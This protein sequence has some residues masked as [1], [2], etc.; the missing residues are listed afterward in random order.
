MSQ[1]AIYLA[2][3]G[4]NATMDRMTAAANNL[5]N[6]S[7]TAFKAQQ[8]VFKAE[9][10]VGQGLP[11][12]VDVASSE[13]TADFK[14]GAL[15]QT[16]RSLDVAVGGSGWIA[17]QANDGTPALTR[18]GALSISQTGMLETSAGNPVLGAGGAP[19][20]LPPLQSVT[21]GED[22]TISGV[23]L[24][25]PADQITTLNRILL[26]NPPQTTLHR[27]ADGLFADQSGQPVPDA[28]VRLQVGALEGSNANP[29]ALMM[30]MIENA[31]MFQMQTELVHQTI[32]QG[33][34]QSSPLSL[35]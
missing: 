23:L 21:I 34:G 9:P 17:V 4:L 35:S 2:A 24:G 13:D 25:T 1:Q 30:S 33:Q 6:A 16:G 19:I 3:S 32:S 20:T 8:P 28:S 22:G 15:E 10:Y 7:T 29:V 18:N 31:R 5:A 26:T 14:P 27:R 11:D 12:R